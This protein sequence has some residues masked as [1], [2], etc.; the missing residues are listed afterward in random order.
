MTG[1]EGRYAL[2]SLRDFDHHTGHHLLQLTCNFILWIYSIFCF[3]RST[4]IS[5]HQGFRLHD[6]RIMLQKVFE[7][8][9]KTGIKLCT[10]CRFYIIKL[11]MTHM[12]IHIPFH[13]HEWV[14][15]RK[16]ADISSNQPWRIWG[17]TRRK[18]DF[19][20]D[21]LTKRDFTVSCNMAAS[22]AAG[23]VKRKLMEPRYP[24]YPRMLGMYF[25]DTT[26]GWHSNHF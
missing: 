7:H 14:N 9:H 15:R 26:G 22:K 2:R 19:L 13:Y 8:L 17:N 21:Q 16:W 20:Q 5:P 12:F 25:S 6:R 23:L 18:V 10:V 1:V 3:L 11:L 24:G 4:M